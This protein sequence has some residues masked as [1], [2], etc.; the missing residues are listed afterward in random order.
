MR[1]EIEFSGVAYAVFD[2][3]PD[4]KSWYT[5]IDGEEHGY[6]D[7]MLHLFGEMDLPLHLSFE[8]ARGIAN[9]AAECCGYTAKW[10]DEKRSITAYGYDRAYRVTY[11]DS[12][13]V[14]VEDITIE[15]QIE[16]LE[17]WNDVWYRRIRG[18]E[19]LGVDPHDKR[20]PADYLQYIDE[21]TR[22][23]AELKEK[24]NVQNSNG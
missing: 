9:N 1:S 8:Q 12:G 14:N 3:G 7:Q 23:I 13:I 2:Y 10:S 15:S 4:H 22:K 5:D 20:T 11:D 21:N 18:I 24:M 17:A 16:D 6:N 19:L